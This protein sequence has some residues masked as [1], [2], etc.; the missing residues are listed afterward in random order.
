MLVSVTP[1]NSTRFFWDRPTLGLLLDLCEEN[2]CVLLKLAPALRSLEGGRHSRLGNGVDLH[3][4]VL[5]QTPYSSLVRLTHYFQEEGDLS[6]VPAALLRVYY[7]AR[8]V[9]VVSLGDWSNSVD[10]IGSY[11]LES[12]WRLN[13]FLSKWLAYLVSQ[14]HGFGPSQAFDP[15]LSRSGRGVG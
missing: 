6:S 13:L 1:W 5:D 9:E 10:R 7:D 2:Y 3:L 8:Q 15:M 11:R 4:E 14:G 12:K